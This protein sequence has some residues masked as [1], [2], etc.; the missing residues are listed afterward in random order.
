MRLTHYS[1]LISIKK[2]RPMFDNQILIESNFGLI[3]EIMTCLA[4]LYVQCFIEKFAN[5]YL[6]K[7]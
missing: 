7:F 3:E 6:M 1:T 5:N 2:M 4:I